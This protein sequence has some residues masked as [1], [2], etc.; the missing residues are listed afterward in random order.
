MLGV[1][2]LRCV[3]QKWRSHANDSPAPKELLFMYETPNESIKVKQKKFSL[4]CS[5]II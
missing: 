2:C 4:L 5:Q 1:G 3:T